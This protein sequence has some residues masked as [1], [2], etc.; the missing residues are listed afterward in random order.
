MDFLDWSE[1]AFGSK[2]V[3]KKRKKKK[4]KISKEYEF[5][6]SMMYAIQAITDHQTHEIMTTLTDEANKLLEE[7]KID[8]TI[9]PKDNHYNNDPYSYSHE[10]RLKKYLFYPNTKLY[11]GCYIMYSDYDPP[12]GYDARLKYN[13]KLPVT[14]L[15]LNE[16]EFDDY[17]TDGIL[18][19]ASK[20]IDKP[21]L[22]S[23]LTNEE[24]EIRELQKKQKAREYA[25][26]RKAKR[27]K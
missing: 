22:T 26:K 24:R 19:D 7:S 14:A 27:K 1:Q 6:K 12:S 5:Q 2:H 8:L 25:A 3:N 9:S 11:I 15:K 21:E 16:K 10:K 18:C 23:S 4:I 20:D 17:I 13:F